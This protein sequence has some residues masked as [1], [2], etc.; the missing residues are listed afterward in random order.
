MSFQGLFESA[1]KRKKEQQQS[2]P[3]PSDTTT[4]QQ[5]Q[6]GRVRIGPSSN[7]KRK[8]GGPV[9]QKALELSAKLKDLSRQKR[10]DQVLDLYWKATERDSH[11]SCMVIDCCAR[12]GHVAEA[13]RVFQEADD[14]ASNVEIHTALLKAFAH[15]GQMA[16]ADALFSSMCATQSQVAPNVRTLNTL[17]RG[18]LWT[19]ACLH[20]GTVVGGVVTS[21]RAWIMFKAKA[22]EDSLDASSYEYSISLLCQ[23]LRVHDALQRIVQFLERNQIKLKGKASF[24]GGDQTSL[25]TLAVAYVS[26]AKA[27]ALLGSWDDTWTACQR[28][29]S[30]IDSS[31]AR[32]VSAATSENFTHE[33]RHVVATGGKQSWKRGSETGTHRQAS[34][35]SF[36]SHRLSELESE[37]RTILKTRSGDLRAA[38]A[39]SLSQSLLTRL[40]Y[41]SGG[42]TTELDLNGNSPRATSRA[43]LLQRLF[44]PIWYSFGLASLVSRDN[45]SQETPERIPEHS[46]VYQL[47]GVDKI[48]KQ[49]I[50][51]RGRIEVDRLFIN[52]EAPI[53]VEMGSGFGEWIENQAAANPSRNYI[54]VELRADRVSQIFI[55]STLLRRLSNVCVV[56]SDAT[57]FFRTQLPSSRISNV[58]VNHPE[59][60][61]QT[62]GDSADDLR[63]VANGGDEP[64]HML[65]S[66]VFIAV[67]DTLTSG[68]KMFII[69]DN[70]W[71]ARLI[72]ATIV[73]ANR[74]DT[75]KLHT[76]SPSEAKDLGLQFV[77]PFE[78]G[79]TLYRTVHGSKGDTGKTWFDRLWQTGA[80]RHAER[81]TRYAIVV[82]KQQ[83]Q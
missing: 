67:A 77:E 79:V 5:K 76:P 61:T 11:H 14:A 12:C 10:L 78:N 30:A 31:R 18:C 83:I 27:Y 81:T 20:E 51:K 40:L 8:R 38:S 66:A 13:E 32:T 70:R 44:I 25:E 15:A 19:A 35:T 80:G 42:G 26:L 69:S 2:T 28:A 34:N 55:K 45:S 46:E 50:S 74:S 71:Y 43:E 53:D 22:G 1:K 16:K 72:C 37:A 33:T 58:Y 23:A 41:F 63:V 17:L 36:R 49:L 29:L 56:A 52:S 57:S 7:K 64:A 59:P 48:M 68:G 47:V 24:R 4:L 9:S 3:T 82:T 62:F 60:P 75:C 6:Q 21:E 54:A 73:K 65:S 39:T